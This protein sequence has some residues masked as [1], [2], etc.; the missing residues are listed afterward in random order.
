MR[1]AVF[2][3]ALSLGGCGYGLMQTAHTERSATVG[4]VVGGT[5]VVNKLSGLAGRTTQTNLGGVLAPRVGIGDHVD[6]GL[7]PWMWVGAR[8]DVKVDLLAPDNPLAIAPRAGGGYATGDKGDQ[9]MA[10]AGAIASYRIGTRFEPYLGATYADHWISL[11]KD[12]YAFSFSSGGTPVARNHT[13][14]GLVELT[15][16]SEIRLARVSGLLFEYNLWL[17]ANNDPGD[18]YAFVTT[19]VFALG[20]HFFSPP[21]H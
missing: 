16:G 11:T 4:G 14:D 1:A 9:F 10:M 21:H 13:G 15:V 19:H 5:Y 3:L 17:P 8:A 6:V 12:E 2:V 7:Q 18:G 20:F